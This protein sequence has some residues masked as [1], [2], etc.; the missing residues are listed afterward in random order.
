MST[1]I[2]LKARFGSR[3]RITFDPAYDAKGKH[4]LDPWMMQLSGRYGTIYP[5]SADLLAVECDYHPQAAKKLAALALR[6]IQDGTGEK[7]FVFPVEQ[8]E[9]V[10]AIVQ[11][12]RK[13]TLSPEQRAERVQRLAAYRFAATTRK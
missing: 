6:C 5:H 10:A 1:P 9:D 12:K 11:P 8:F 13:R 4:L 7:T 2:N 3:Y